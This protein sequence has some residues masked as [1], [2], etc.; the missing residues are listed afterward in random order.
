MFI[1]IFCLLTAHHLTDNSRRDLAKDF[2]KAERITLDSST[3]PT[4]YKKGNI[5]VLDPA[6]SL[7]PLIPPDTSP[8][9]YFGWGWPE[10]CAI[11]SLLRLSPGQTKVKD[12]MLNSV[13][14]LDSSH[15]IYWKN[16]YLK[17][18]NIYSLV[19]NY[20]K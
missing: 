8:S 14:I 11:L 10:N 13:Y 20:A 15:I 2:W 1:C 19:R 3:L 18:E 5:L 7:P 9:S 12:P 4:K 17:Q 16:K 6:W